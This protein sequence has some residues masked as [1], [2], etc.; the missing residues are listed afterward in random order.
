MRVFHSSRTEPYSDDPEHWRSVIHRVIFG[1]STPA[2]RRFDLLLLV[3]IISSV[4]AVML[5]S[6]AEVR[7][8]YGTFLFT[9]EWVF[10]IV[11]AIEYIARLLSVKRP[12]RYALSFFGIVDL[13]AVL[14][15]FIAF[16]IPAA[17]SLMTVRILRMLRVFR[18]MK[19]VA[20]LREAQQLSDAL[21]A[22]RRK[23]T[24]FLT[25]VLTLVVILG[26]IMYLIED[27]SSG[28]TS[29]PRSIYWAIVT[30]TTVG[31]GDIAPS[32]PIG[33]ALAAFI[34]LLGYSIIAIPTGIVSTEIAK[35]GFNREERGKMCRSCE[36]EGQDKDAKFCK[37][38][39]E[40]FAA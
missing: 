40:K 31:Y 17:T 33:Q 4:I 3:V 9:I 39:G 22:S 6:V 13:L 30:L 32:S 36:T 5:E 8:E 27:A 18:I 38:C 19:L 15:T 7:S 24:I 2:G 11:F 34:M 23:I 14:P 37:N 10:T 21:K 28:F 16:F 29:I 25:T 20:F 26:T 35:A 1:T 12:L